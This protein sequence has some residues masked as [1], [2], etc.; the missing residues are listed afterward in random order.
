M[1]RNPVGWNASML[2]VK[3]STTS[4][5]GGV[6]NIVGCRAPTSSAGDMSD[7]ASAWARRCWA[8]ASGSEPPQPA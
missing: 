1:A 6:A 7:N 2:T 3:A 4:G 5:G 8:T